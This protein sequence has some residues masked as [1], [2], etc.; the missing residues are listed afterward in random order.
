ML[1]NINLDRCFRPPRF[2]R[3]IDCSLHHFSDANQDGYVQVSYLRLMNKDSHIHCSLVTVK[4]RVTLLKFVSIPRLELMAPALSIK[5]SLL[6]KKEL[7]NIIN[8]L[9]NLIGLIARWYWDT[10]EMKQRDLKFL[11][12]T[13]SRSLEKIQV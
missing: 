11:W 2:G 6:L 1:E 10:S 13:E 5:V 7:T 3:L 8:Q 12:Q 9:E 4:P